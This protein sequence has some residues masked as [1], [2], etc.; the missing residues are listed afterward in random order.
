MKHKWKFWLAPLVVVLAL[1]LWKS[2]EFLKQKKDT[3]PQERTQTVAVQDVGKV[4][5]EET[6]ALAGSLEALNEAVI[7]PKVPG[8]VSRVLVENGA[9]VAAGQ[10][11]VLLEDTEYNNA[12]AIA[13]ATLKKAEANLASVRVNYERC[14][15][16]YQGKVISEKDFEDAQTGLMLAEADTDAAAAAVANAEE[17]LRG[18][19][20]VSP[21]NGVVANR[22]VTPGQV[23]A[24]GFTL[25]AVEDISSVYVL[26]NTEQKDL[27]KV[28][29]GLPASVTVD[30]YGGNKFDGVVE[31]IN[32]SANNSARVF[33]TK[34]RVGNQEGLL[35]PGMFASVQIKTGAEG[36]VLA[37]PQNSLVSVQGM[38]FAFVPEGDRVKRQQVEIGQV[39]D[40]LV[41]IKSGLEASQK[42][43]VTNVNKLKDQDK[44]IIAN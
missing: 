33:E 1:G 25:M 34:I 24:A 41:E 21:L 27:G 10:P 23:V 40:Q 32:P 14:R 42:I 29:P 36:E 39:I 5:K 43:V 37:V 20:V 3:S 13:R 18:A 28:K 19:T 38:F 44:I 12:L 17:A 9:F 15:E 11:L 26:V 31:I 22:N 8:R 7:S 35:K 4:N 30:S 6:V 2:G 16:M